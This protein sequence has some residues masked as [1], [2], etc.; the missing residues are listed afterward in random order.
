MQYAIIFRNDGLLYHNTRSHINTSHMVF[1]Y[2]TILQFNCCE[3]SVSL[4]IDCLNCCEDYVSLNID[5]LNCCE[6]SVLLNI[7]FLN[8]CEDSNI[9]YLWSAGMLLTQIFFSRCSMPI[10][11]Y[12]NTKQKK[13][14]T[15]YFAQLNHITNYLQL[16][17][18]PVKQAVWNWNK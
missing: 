13:G 3:D 14:L 5:F 15:K 9:R 12:L 4:N 8:C 16:C 1:G 10:L 18:Y 11:K 17:L 6:D 7:D 2:V